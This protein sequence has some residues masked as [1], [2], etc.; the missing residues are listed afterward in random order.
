MQGT[1]G[2]PLRIIERVAACDYTTFGVCLLHD[3]N[4]DEVERIK[5]DHRQ[6]GTEGI[7]QAIIRQWLA[8][9]GPTCTYQHLIECLNQAGLGALAENIAENRAQQ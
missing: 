8:S 5:R 3:E 1:D 4:G 2:T 7:T 6:D 9:G